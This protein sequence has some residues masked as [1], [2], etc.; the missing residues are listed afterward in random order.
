MS[1]RESGSWRGGAQKK[2]GAA[3]LWG[4]NVKL[5]AT[6]GE[7]QRG[8]EMRYTMRYNK[9]VKEQKNSKDT[10]SKDFRGTF[11]KLRENN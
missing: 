1:A 5:E 9:N 8:A 3:K 2:A 6:E 11:F 4:D 10:C 7:Q